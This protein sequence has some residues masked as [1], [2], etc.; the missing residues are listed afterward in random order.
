MYDRSEATARRILNDKITQIVYSKG[1]I[2]RKFSDDYDRERNIHEI[3]RII[4]N[5]LAKKYGV[6]LKKGHKIVQ[7]LFNYHLMSDDYQDYKKKK[8]SE[9]SKSD[10]DYDSLDDL[11]EYLSNN[12]NCPDRTLGNV[13]F[14]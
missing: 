13:I 10:R 14:K 8:L 5:S 2:T 4:K 7:E 11:D 9:W 3:D 1:F 6:G 12:K